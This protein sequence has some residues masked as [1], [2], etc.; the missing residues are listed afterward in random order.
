MEHI[1]T[2][3]D[4]VNNPGIIEDPSLVI[5]IN[6]KWDVKIVVCQS[7]F[8]FEVIVNTEY[9]MVTCVCYSYYNWAVAAPMVLSM[10]AFQKNLPKVFLFYIPY[11]S[12]F[13]TH[14]QLQTLDIK[15]PVIHCTWRGG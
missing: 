2:Y 9:F 8:L 4:F 7:M 14:Y 15:D 6:S 12:V 1:V 11:N 10:T 3:Q 5:C 13:C